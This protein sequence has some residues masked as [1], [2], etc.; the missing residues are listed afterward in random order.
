MP[1]S[2]A[3]AH[4]HVN[5]RGTTLT[6]PQPEVPTAQV[7][8]YR[9]SPAQALLRDPTTLVLTML[10]WP[11]QDRDRHRIAPSISMQHRSLQDLALAHA[12]SSSPAVPSLST[13]CPDLRTHKLPSASAASVPAAIEDVR[14]HSRCRIQTPRAFAEARLSADV[15]T[16]LRM[17]HMEATTIPIH[18]RHA[19]GRK[20]VP[21]EM[22]S[23]ISRLEN[24]WYQVG[25]RPQSDPLPGSLQCSSLL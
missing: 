12:L 10:R 5:A 24:L 1:W 4:N 20:C 3:P 25:G 23:P 21:T 22:C 8:L 14:A 7:R 17:A 2:S 9:W 13:S 16:V 6:C 11:T 15:I 19:R 18:H